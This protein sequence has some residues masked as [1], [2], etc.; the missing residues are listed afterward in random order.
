MPAPA[1]AGLVVVNH[2]VLRLA[3]LVVFGWAAVGARHARVSAGQAQARA[4][5]RQAGAVVGMGGTPQGMTHAP[6]GIAAA[7]R[8]IVRS[9]RPLGQSTPQAG[10]AAPAA[11]TR[12]SYRAR[13][14]RYR[15]RVATRTTGDRGI[16]PWPPTAAAGG[17]PVPGHLLALDQ[18]TSSSRAILFD[19]SG[20][21]VAMAQRELTQRYPRPGW[22]EHDPEEIWDGQLA[23]ARQVLAQA[24]VSARDVK[25][26]GITNQR[27]TTIVWDRATGRAVHPAIVWQDRRTADTC[28]RM[29]AE[30]WKE[31]VTHRTGLVLDPYFSATKLQWLLE[32]VD[33]LRARAT[34]GELAFGTVDSWLLHRLTGG[35]VH[36]TDVTNAARTLLFDIHRLCWDASL[37]AA[38]D[39]PA[40]L[41]PEVRPC[42]SQFGQTLPEW[43]GVSIPITGVA[44]DQHAALF[45]QGCLEQGMAKNT[46]GTGAFL[47]VHTGDQPVRVPGL[48]TTLAWQLTG[49][50]AEYAV[51]ASIFV[52]GAAVQWL[53][54]GLGLIHDA[55]E[56]GPLAARVPDSGGVYFVPALTGLGAPH[57]DPTA[58]GLIIGLT[59]GSGAAH[60]ARATL[61]AIA[62][63]TRDAVTAMETAG[64]HLRELRVDG[65]ATGNDLLLQLQADILGVPVLRPAVTETTAMGAAALAAV[66][67]GLWSPTEVAARWRLASR[68]DPTPHAA[69]HEAGYEGWR[70]AVARSLAWETSRADPVSPR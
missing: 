70:R 24:G 26:L 60:L 55:Q 1:P 23:A 30:G 4:T 9:P 36:A 31:Q 22:V 42:A 46:Y 37:L 3:A 48:L 58:R 51:E 43:L 63:Q 29:R 20:L 69:V 35:A 15:L 17:I 40:A 53:R 2:A 45:G 5:R 68:F 27:E 18:G 33:G 59:R 47:V 7:L 10:Q 56:I 28:A 54:D 49:A 38:F 21:P 62:Y 16:P 57:W 6:R 66:G 13:S 67:A 50:P 19:T 34:A 39:I 61:E 64:G 32:H 12:R 25:A 41:L 11:K 44:G 8:S 52:A 14:G 65:G